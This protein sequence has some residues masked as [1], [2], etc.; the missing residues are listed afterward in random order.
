[1]HHRAWLLAT[2]A[3]AAGLLASQ[4]QAQSR[5][6]TQAAASNTIEE[7]VVTAERREQS[8]QD[9]PVAI[10][11]F[12]SEKRDLIGINTIQ[13]MTNFTPGLNYSSATDRISL[14]GVGRLTNAHPIDTAVATYSDNIYTT[15]TVEAGKTPIFVD[16]VEVLRGPQGTLYGRNSI[17]GAINVISK[18][19]TEDFYGEVR[20]TV[21]NYERTL[22]EAAVSGP[23]APGLQARLAGNWERQKKGY[24]ENIVPGMPSEGNVVDQ[25]Y[26]EAQFQAQFGEKLE[27]WVKGAIAGWNNGGGGPGARAG[28]SPS[29][30]AFGEF[31]AQNV[32]AGFACAPGGTA[33]PV[34]INVVNTSPL[35]CTNA[36]SQDPRKFANRIAQ[37]VS[38]DETYVISAQ[39]TYHFDGMDLKYIVG[40]NN[41]HYTLFQD[42]GTGAITSFQIPVRKT[43]IPG[44][45]VASFQ[46]CVATNLAA[47]GACA[48]LTIFPKQTSTYQELYHNI[49]HEL[50]L[51]STND[52][53]LQWIGGLYYYFEGY[54]QPVFTTLHEQPQILNSPVA[55]APT[56]TGSVLPPSFQRRLYDD[57]PQFKM[58]SY[59]AYGQIDWQFTD[60][61]KTTLGLRYSHDEK[62]GTESV[63]VICFA[64]TACGTPPELFGAFTPVV[65]VTGAVV[66]VGVDPLQPGVN[67]VPKGVVPGPNGGVTF[68]RNTGFAT[69][70]YDA[71]WEAVTGTAGL[72]WDP[73]P[74]TM[75]YAR[76]SRGYKAGGFNSGITT[77]LG[78]F[79]YTDAEYIDD[80]ELGLKK[81]FGRWLQTNLALFHYNYENLQAPLTVANNSG[82]LAASQSRFLNVPKSVSQGIELETIW[83][84]IDNLSILF[85]YSY[86]DAHVEE[87]SGVYDP[88]DPLAI[89]PGATPTDPALIRCRNAPGA[90]AVPGVLRPCDTNTGFYQRQQN[91]KGNSLPQAA[92]NKVA[93]NVSYSWDLSAGTLTP[94]LSYIWRDKEYSSLFERETNASKAWDQVDLRAT[95]SD[96]DRKYTIIAYVKNLFDELGYAG[97]AGGSRRGGTYALGT[98]GITPGTDCN[99]NPSGTCIPGTVAGVQGLGFTYALTPPR[100]YGVEFQYRF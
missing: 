57:R 71:S 69:R 47:P 55:A 84:P 34:V 86:N 80:I 95:W 85:N 53:K 66:Y 65:D 93:F 15:S 22:L 68:D 59:A 44:F 38:L 37:S 89:A 62:T 97:G 94:S 96:H 52:S 28:Y 63:R 42:N 17:G 16:R 26:I 56:L 5:G 70:K 76:Y 2:G 72:Q 61:L 29:P 32:S 31:G 4:A 23:L 92:K 3:L 14:R 6:A 58:E 40:G 74:D 18:H 36:A 64:T 24:Y 77:T 25:W 50:N 98:P 51:A 75:V 19:P 99:L 82:T 67:V 88:D 46:P 54:E 13:D 8:L 49:S 35:G 12:T 1:M 79:P 9:V 91:L 30:T 87:L 90:P 11:A 20:G 60:T 83:A 48:P 27:G 39:L 10:S 41:Y 81:N 78:E 33:G 73:D 100:T 7:L 45:P 43:L 21:A